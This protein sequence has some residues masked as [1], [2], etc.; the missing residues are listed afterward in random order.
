MERYKNLSG[1]SPI[2]H[3]QIEDDRIIVLFD[4]GKSYSYSYRRASRYNVERMKVLAKQGK[5][6]CAYITRHVRNLYD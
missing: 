1:N 2:T 5:G 6:L 4:T 3:Y